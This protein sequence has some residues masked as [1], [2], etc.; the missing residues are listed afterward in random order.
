MS[1]SVIPL[2]GD[3]NITCQDPRTVDPIADTSN[4][5]LDT[6]SSTVCSQAGVTCLCQ[7]KWQVRSEVGSKG[8]LDTIPRANYTVC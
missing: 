3:S 4:T 8:N 7:F 2:L 1:G 6:G 5:S